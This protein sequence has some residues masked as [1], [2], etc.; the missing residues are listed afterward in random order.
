MDSFTSKLSF[1]LG[2]AEEDACAAEEVLQDT[3]LFLLVLLGSLL[4]VL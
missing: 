4:V 1:A 2:G 3:L